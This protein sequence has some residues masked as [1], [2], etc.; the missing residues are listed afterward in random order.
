MTAQAFEI[1]LEELARR[2]AE[3]LQALQGEE[4]AQGAQSAGSPWLSIEAASRYLD[5]PKQRLY[6]LTA[7]GEIPHYK[8][9]GRLL[10][11][12]EELDNWLRE[13]AQGRR[14]GGDWM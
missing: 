9:E 5:W 8:H 6:K 10:F 14:D 3:R 1:L 11:R 13:F 2:V 7:A 4:R 12:R